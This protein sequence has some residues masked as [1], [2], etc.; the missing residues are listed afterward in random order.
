MTRRGAL[1]R[2][3][4]YG[5][6]TLAAGLA[7]IFLPHRLSTDLFDLLPK[8]HPDIDAARAVAEKFGG[9][10]QEIISIGWPAGDD[11]ARQ[12]ATALVDELAP[13]LRKEPAIAEVFGD[14]HHSQEML[15]G[16]GPIYLDLLPADKLDDF[17]ARLSPEGMK[18]ALAGGKSLM[19]SPTGLMAAEF[20]R[21]DP[22]GLV[23]M[24]LGRQTPPGKTRPDMMS[25]MLLAPDDH[26]ALLL[27]RGRRPVSEMAAAHALLGAV[28]RAI[29][30]AKSAAEILPE[31]GIEITHTG[32]YAIA[33]RDEALI[34]HDATVGSLLTIFLVTLVIALVTRSLRVPA[35]V[36]APLLAATIWLAA[37][38]FMSPWKIGASA[39]GSCGILMGLGS[40]LA[41]V[42]Y[43]RVVA[44]LQDGLTPEAAVAQAK[45]QGRG[46]VW[47]CA[48]T[49][50]A[51]FAAL[52]LTRF[53]ILQQLG[54]IVAAGI[55]LAAF[56]ILELLPALLLVFMPKGG[57]PPL[58]DLGLSR[59]TKLF[60]PRENG[61]RR[62]L[63]AAWIIGMVM[64]GA[65]CVFAWQR[66]DFDL[67]AMH[68]DSNPEVQRL[69]E[70]LDLFGLPRESQVVML[71]ADSMPRLLVRCRELNKAGLDK[72]STGFCH[73]IPSDSARA[74]EMF[75]LLPNVIQ[76]PDYKKYKRSNEVDFSA[77]LIAAG[78][79]PE[80][81][82]E[83]LLFIKSLTTLNSSSAC[84]TLDVEEEFNLQ[85]T[86]SI[87]SSSYSCLS[88]D[89]IENQPLLK[90]WFR[91]PTKDDPFFYAQVVLPLDSTLDAK[92]F[93]PDT[94]L[95]SMPATNRA[96]A[97]MGRRD[98][99]IAF[100]AGIG[101]LILLHALVL[102]N[103]VKEIWVL[104]LYAVSPGILL[105]PLGLGWLKIDILALA[106]VLIL[107]G[108]VTDY[109]IQWL[110]AFQ[111]S[112][113]D[114]SSPNLRAMVG[115]A[116]ALDAVTTLIAFLALLTAQYTGMRNL[117]W[118]AGAGSFAG[119]I[120]ALMG[121][122]SNGRNKES[123]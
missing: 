96:L 23:G 42:L 3:W 20:F 35:M 76:V 40:D 102:R 24:V 65:F 36:M 11:E 51:T 104:A 72:A 30:A 15:K 6:L 117:G 62:R 1:A 101:A 77:A 91:G 52:A 92:S 116:L 105:I 78:Y 21:Q 55:L 9:A 110:A 14:L 107:A 10:D 90:E 64:T 98:I 43:A 112:S 18:A 16:L 73:W 53:P 41:I 17:N 60:R 45:R 59:F 19:S 58:R 108:I 22:L 99:V 71:N 84:T 75:S 79:R 2:V 46:A 63:L 13:L 48:A 106:G 32:G 33:A 50:A 109:G 121:T 80:M 94:Q 118:V 120:Y 74:S 67:A 29:A 81:F 88:E 122:W 82:H 8:G 97:E 68:R 34:R 25:G 12:A 28:D 47:L 86:V 27:V 115:N 37:L 111:P 87:F 69:E 123:S 93:P 66:A 103:R 119:C 95:M 26:H 61:S 56:A 49:T 114:N 113:A 39:A 7:A 89:A 54:L 100:L 44:A 83:S 57:Y 5:L 38:I 4:I 31:D 70:M 85:S